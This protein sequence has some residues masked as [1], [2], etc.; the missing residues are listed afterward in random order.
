MVVLPES[1]LAIFALVSALMPS[2]AISS[3]AARTS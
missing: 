1:R 3:A 2:S